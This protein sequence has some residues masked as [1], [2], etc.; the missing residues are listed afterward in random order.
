VDDD[1]VDTQP[2]ALPNNVPASVE[3]R[4][5]LAGGNQELIVDN[6][7]APET[8]PQ[9]DTSGTVPDAAQEVDAFG[10][11]NHDLSVPA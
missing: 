7:E 3:A 2:I 9:L 10:E 1:A 8:G 4:D 6:A 11:P 5:I